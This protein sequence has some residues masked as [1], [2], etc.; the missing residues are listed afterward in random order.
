MVGTGF[1]KAEEPEPAVGR[2]LV[3]QLTAKSANAWDLRVLMEQPV[4][5]AV[6]AVVPIPDCPGRLAVTVNAQVCVFEINPA[7]TESILRMRCKTK[8]QV[9]CCFPQSL[10]FLE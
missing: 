2:M 10:K 3:L 1:V 7:N 4:N 8:A 9:Q 5:G 6:Y